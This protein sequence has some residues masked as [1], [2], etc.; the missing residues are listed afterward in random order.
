MI[1]NFFYCNCHY[2]ISL[3][4]SE[5]RLSIMWQYHNSVDHNIYNL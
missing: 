5:E 4:K 1:L 3:V 2:Q